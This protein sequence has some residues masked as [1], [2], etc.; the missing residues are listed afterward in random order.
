MS[1]FRLSQ[2]ARRY[3][4]DIN[5]KS[6]TG[7]FDTIWDQYYLS[8]MA[9][10]KARRRVPTD[11]EPNKS[12]EFLTEVS[13]EFSDQR[14]E[15]YSAMITAE[16]EREAIPWG[17]KRELRQLMLDT[18]DSASHTSLARNGSIVLNCY[19]KRGY[20]IIESRIPEPVELDEFLEQYYYTIQDIN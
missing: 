16:I 17:Q 10:I 12:Q 9:G 11:E 8:A 18:L 2:N 20:K 15:I 19:A 6:T 5:N 1:S 4:Q 14:Y 7:E 3:F 13:D